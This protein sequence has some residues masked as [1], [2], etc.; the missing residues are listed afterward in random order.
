MNTEQITVNT[1][2]S[3]RIN[4]SRVLYFDPFQIRK[5]THDADIIL[6]THAHYDHFDPESIRRVMKEE[7]VFVAPSGM[8]KEINEV[9]GEREKILMT[10]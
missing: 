9:S 3:I 5:E 8:W 1:Q 6:I 4:G 7:T 2:S 10:P